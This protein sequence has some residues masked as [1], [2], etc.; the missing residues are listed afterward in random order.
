MWSRSLA[1]LLELDP[2]CGMGRAGG[3]GVCSLS[4]ALL[5]RPNLLRTQ[6]FSEFLHIVFLQSLEFYL[7]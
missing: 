2:V 1:A 5:P 4:C 6:D 7:V 3:P